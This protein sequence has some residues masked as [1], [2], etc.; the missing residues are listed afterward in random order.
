ME[1]EEE[2][3]KAYVLPSHLVVVYSEIEWRQSFPSPEKGE[4]LIWHCCELASELSKSSALSEGNEASVSGFIPPTPADFW[5]QPKTPC[6]FLLY[7]NYLWS[8]EMQM[9][10]LV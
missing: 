8:L 7:A 2:K 3:I 4:L 6:I 10:H 1:Q 5:I 9:V